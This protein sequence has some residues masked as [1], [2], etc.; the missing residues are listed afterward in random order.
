M[1]RTARVVRI[2]WGR[3][4][5]CS[6]MNVPC[7]NENAGLAA[8]CVAAPPLETVAPTATLPNNGAA[9]E[10]QLGT[11][12]VVV[13]DAGLI[14]AAEQTCAVLFQRQPAE[15]VGQPLEVLLVAGTDKIRQRL[16]SDQAEPGPGSPPPA[17]LFALAQRKDGTSF[18]VAVTLERRPPGAACWWAVVFHEVNS[19][20]SARSESPGIRHS[21]LSPR[22]R[23]AKAGN[24]PGL[25]SI[26]DIFQQIPAPA[27]RPDAPGKATG[28]PA[29]P[30]APV[31]RKEDQQP[32][33]VAA[34][35]KPAEANSEAHLHE[36]EQRL[37]ESAEE[38]KRTQ[39]HVHHQD[40]QL[41]AA[42]AAAQQ[43]VAALEAQ[44]VRCGQSEEQ[45]AQARQTGDELKTR[46]SAEQQARA[47][48]ETRLRELEKR[49]ARSSEELKQAQARIKQ[50]PAPAPAPNRDEPPLQDQLLQLEAR[51][52]TAVASLARATTELETERGQRRR[53]EQRATTLAGQLQQLHDEL[54][55][56][57]E[58]GQADQQ[59]I[60]DLEHQLQE[61]IRQNDLA[62]GKLQSALQHEEC[63][64]KRVEAE[65]ARSRLLSTDS[66]R[67]SRALVNGL[68]RQLLPP[69]ESLHDS[70]CRLLQLE[71]SD[72]Q[73]RL[74]QAVLENTLLV[75]T[76]LQESPEG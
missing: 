16:V 35:A 68:R 55:H 9:P 52:R 53:S 28:A 33:P 51:L 61:Q 11:G 73:K 4:L 63:E 70:A 1:A 39:A 41:H 46:L 19:P 37:N 30:S 32:A 43:A 56:H 13:D 20:S 59:R 44:S 27:R 69:V 5:N 15:L 26:P 49:L 10:P 62:A 25:E 71:L 6:F 45:L 7:L 31:A 67:A 66:A 8:S 36:L 54:K 64:R 76:S 72:D 58:S 40:E 48:S 3:K 14:V 75:Q 21:S 47:G 23:R 2:D 22:P 60:A 65:L 74:V 24:S 29:E 12:V 18:P 34:P 17:R 38:L 57:L 50:Q 42:K